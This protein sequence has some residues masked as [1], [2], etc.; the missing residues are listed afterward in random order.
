MRP[1]QGRPEGKY[2]ARGEGLR[3]F[4]QYQELC[5]GVIFLVLS[6][7]PQSGGENCYLVTRVG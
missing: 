1:S 5:E 4:C 2:G 7:A 6:P 3:E